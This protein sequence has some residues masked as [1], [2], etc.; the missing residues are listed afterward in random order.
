MLKIDLNAKSKNEKVKSYCNC[1]SFC[2][3]KIY[4]GVNSRVFVKSVS[5]EMSKYMKREVFPTVGVEPKV[6]VLKLT[7]NLR[8]KVNLE[9]AA[10]I[11]NLGTSVK[12][13]YYQ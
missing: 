8:H 11:V 10:E 9:V 13:S 1:G 6:I 3:E 4:S 12:P 5:G 2:S 7:N